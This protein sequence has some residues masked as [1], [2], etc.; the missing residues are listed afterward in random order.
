MAS[1]YDCF[2]DAERDYKRFLKSDPSVSCE[3]G[4]FARISI[5]VHS[6]LMAVFVGLGFPLFSFWKIQQLKRAGALDANSS[7][8]SLYQ[9]R[10]F[11][12]CYNRIMSYK[13]NKTSISPVLQY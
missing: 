4:S 1:M 10:L 6:I 9:V 11:C 12:T 3:D 8:S 13:P 2:D 5:D 7:F